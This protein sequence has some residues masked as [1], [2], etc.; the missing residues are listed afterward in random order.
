[1]CLPV[2][3]AQPA[4]TPEFPPERAAELRARARAIRI[5]VEA[6]NEALRGNAPGFADTGPAND[7]DDA[8]EEQ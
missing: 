1:M 5:R 3:E 4:E 7:G 6:S 2:E 8:M